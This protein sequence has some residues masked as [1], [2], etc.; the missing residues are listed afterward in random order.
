VTVAGGLRRSSACAPH[1]RAHPF[2]LLGRV[3]EFDRAVKLPVGLPSQVPNPLDVTAWT[4][5]GNKEA[6]CSGLVWRDEIAGSG[7]HSCH[8]RGRT[9]E[10]RRQ[11]CRS[12]RWAPGGSNPEPAD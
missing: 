12:E 8:V 6:N 2:G 1:L 7:F 3:R 5:T 10:S 9:I 11:S 4:A